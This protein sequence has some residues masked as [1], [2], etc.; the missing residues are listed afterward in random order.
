[1]V[2][3]AGSTAGSTVCEKTVWLWDS[4][5]EV[6]YPSTCWSLMLYE[7]IKRELDGNVPWA[8]YVVLPFSYYVF[9]CL[10]LIYREVYVNFWIVCVLLVDHVLAK[11]SWY[12]TNSCVVNPP[13][14][15]YL[16]IIQMNFERRR[17]RRFHPC[18]LTR[19]TPSNKEGKGNYSIQ[20]INNAPQWNH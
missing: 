6:D 11:W 8:G 12:M 7:R 16:D 19:Y 18:F 2:G 4:E 14:N 10:W 9:K 20:S 3:T 1:M 5:C 17:G 15:L 13:I